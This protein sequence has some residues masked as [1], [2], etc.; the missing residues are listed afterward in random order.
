MLSAFNAL[1]LSPALAAMLL[2]P[3]PQNESTR[4]AWQVL[5]LVQSGILKKLENSYL[6]LSGA[7]IRKSL[8]GV[9]IF[10]Q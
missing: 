5:R 7:I 3:K 8:L 4:T 2:R 10:S 1:S 9:A 6:K